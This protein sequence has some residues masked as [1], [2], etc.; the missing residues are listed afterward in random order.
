MVG[1]IRKPIHAEHFLLIMLIFKS[2]H[3]DKNTKMPIP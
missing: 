3:D 1:F 2:L